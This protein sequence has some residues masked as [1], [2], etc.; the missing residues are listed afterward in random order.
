V[1]QRA[2]LGQVLEI[3]EREVAARSQG[4][5]AIGFTVTVN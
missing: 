2:S 4:R 5:T 1:S 3:V